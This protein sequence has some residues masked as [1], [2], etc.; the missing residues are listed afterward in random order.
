MNDYAGENLHKCG[1][2]DHYFEDEEFDSEVGL[3]K[4]CAG[5]EEYE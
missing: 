3:C 4:N 1:D 5:D 2:C